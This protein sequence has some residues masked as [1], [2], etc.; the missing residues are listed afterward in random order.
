MTRKGIPWMLGQKIF[1]I[2]NLI[3]I[4]S[5]GFSHWHG[6]R[7]LEAF[8]DHLWKALSQVKRSKMNMIIRNYI[9]AIYNEVGWVNQQDV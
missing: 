3:K 8:G 6:K 5:I 7:Y 9:W 4:N 1:C 2:M